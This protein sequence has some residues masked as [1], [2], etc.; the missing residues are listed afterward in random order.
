MEMKRNSPHG[1]IKYNYILYLIFILTSLN[2]R[3]E[4]NK[5]WEAPKVIYQSSSRLII[6]RVDFRK[7]ETCISFEYWASPSSILSLQSRI[8]IFGHHGQSYPVISAQGIELDSVLIIPES[9]MASFSISFEPLPDNI[10]IF[11]LLCNDNNNGIR[12]YGIHPNAEHKLD[13]PQKEWLHD[14]DSIYEWD[15]LDTVVVRGHFIEQESIKPPNEIN[16]PF[17]RDINSGLPNAHICNDGDFVFAF[18]CHHPVW[19]NILVNHQLIQFYGIPGDTIDINISKWNSRDQKISYHSHKN[20]PCLSELMLHGDFIEGSTSLDKLS[21]PAFQ[22]ATDELLAQGLELA[23]YI[24]YRYNL[25]DYETHLLK[26]QMR[27]QYVY[28]VLFYLNNFNAKPNGH[29]QRPKNE[30]DMNFLR[31]INWN[32]P[33]LICTRGWTSYFRHLL[34]RVFSYGRNEEEDFNTIYVKRLVP[35][36]HNLHEYVKRDFEETYHEMYITCNKP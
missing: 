1:C 29:N 10:E 27:L 31:V 26:N 36:M 25:T 32:D 22:E 14:N 30:T 12:I 16:F 28:R 19:S 17:L 23:D 20:N 4:L 2:V 5:T 9:G 13:F 3:A 15:K 21:W 7:H 11:D 33:S 24:A 18:A 6:K 8:R 34:L 35:Y